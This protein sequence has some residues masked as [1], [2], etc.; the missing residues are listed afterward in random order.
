VTPHL[1]PTRGSK[2]VREAAEPFV[3]ATFEGRRSRIE[4][5]ATTG[6]SDER[7]NAV[8]LLARLGGEEIRPF[9]EGVEEDRR[10]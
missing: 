2:E 8:R 6:T 1:L 3:A 9:L 7:F 10:E 4:A 5:K